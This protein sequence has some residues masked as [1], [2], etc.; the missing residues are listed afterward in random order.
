LTTTTLARLAPAIESGD[1]LVVDVR[2]EEEFAV[3]H[4]PGSVHAPE[5]GDVRRLLGERGLPPTT[6]VVVDA[7]GHRA[8]PRASEWQAQADGDVTWLAGGLFAWANGGRKLVDKEGEIVQEVHP[9]HSYWSRLLDEE[10]RAP[11]HGEG[12]NGETMVR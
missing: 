1:V 11:L 9:Y 12:P 2:T 4:L 10:R 5:A 6:I 3:S 7:T 8:A